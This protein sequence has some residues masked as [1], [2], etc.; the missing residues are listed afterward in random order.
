MPSGMR[1]RIASAIASCMLRAMTA[2]TT[3]TARQRVDGIR[4][5]DHQYADI[6]GLTPG[7]L[8]GVIV[9]DPGMRGGY[10]LVGSA[11]VDLD[12]G[13]VS[14]W[15]VSRPGGGWIEG[16]TW[17]TVEAAVAVARDPE[18]LATLVLYAQVRDDAWDAHV[19]ARSLDKQAAELLAELGGA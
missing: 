12:A 14:E 19:R 11:R 8:T 1:Q 5:G 17:P 2:T 6:D 13:T 10:V 4:P 7:T 9:K 15:Q 3:R 16:P 18:R